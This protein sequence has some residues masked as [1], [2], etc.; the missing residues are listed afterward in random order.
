MTH[1]AYLF[2]CI[3]VISVPALSG[4]Y[5]NISIQN[6]RRTILV[7]TTFN[8]QLFLLLFKFIDYLLLFW[9][10]VINIFFIFLYNLLLKQFIIMLKKILIKIGY[11]C[12]SYYRTRKEDPLSWSFLGLL[13]AVSS[14]SLLPL[15][16]PYGFFTH[17]Y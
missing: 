12:Q 8:H 13:A 14:L 3:L 16:R 7:A 6:L 17:I 11:K 10:I 15:H 5:D 4:F 2:S 1:K 9:S